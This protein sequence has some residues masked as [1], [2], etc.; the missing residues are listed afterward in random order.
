M[1]I[2]TPTS[3]QF[4]TVQTPPAAQMDPALIGSP[5]QITAPVTAPVAQTQAAL[6]NPNSLTTPTAVTSEDRIAGI[7]NKGGPLM[8]QAATAGTQQAAS[9]GLLN[10]SMAVQAAQ[11]AVIQAAAPIGTNDANSL[12]QMASN[13]ANTLNQGVQFNANATNSAN[14][15]NA[16]AANQNAQFNT[17]N[18]M[19]AATSNANATNTANQFNANTQNQAGQFNAQ[20]TNEFAKL[21]TQNQ[22]TAN[23]WNA[24]QA[25]EAVLKTMDVNSREQLANIEANYKQLMQTNSSAENIYS[26]VMKNV[27]DIQNNKDIADKETAINSQM[28]WLRSG[29]K[30]IESLNGVTGLVNF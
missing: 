16:G 18:E 3:A 30:M 4:N 27:S 7:L 5:A 2:L 20:S 17:G 24:Q 9:R 22:N 15:W 25:N 29:L 28:G 26:Q 10:S 1:P 13:N 23:Q 11:G 8:Q 12:N 6:I 21:D 14:Q 19:Q